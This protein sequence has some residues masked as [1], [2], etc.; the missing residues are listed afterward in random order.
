MSDADAVTAALAGLID[1]LRGLPQGADDAMRI[2]RITML[3]QL[4]A[5]AAAAQTVEAA[6]FA[7][8]QRA[9][10]RAVGVPAAQ[11][12]RGV[13]AQVGLAR[14]ISPHQA[15]RYLGW[16]TVL[17]TELP[18]TFTALAA[19]KVPERRAE[20]VARETIW[21]TRAHRLAVDAE[22]GPQL[23]TLGDRQV[24]AQARGIGYRLDP[25]GFV[26]R[27]AKAET[28]RR[29]WLRPA[30][31]AMVRLTALLPVAQGVACY[32]ALTRA[33]DTST[34]VGDERG[35]GQLMADTLV[36][37]VTGQTAA[38]DVP[39]SI[40]LTITD[41]ALLHNGTEPAIVDGYGPIPAEQARDLITKPG[42][43]TPMWI[44]RLYTNPESGQL[45]AMESKQRFFTAGQ[46][47]FIRIRDQYCR[48]PYCGAPIRHADH[49]RPA[50]DGGP[51]AIRN[52]QGNCEACNHAK[53]APGWTT[54]VI[55]NDDGVHEVETTTPTGHTYRSRAPDPPRRDVA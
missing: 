13:A 14:R 12:G 31:E 44:R 15:A 19:G 36:E 16:A 35:R 28:E 1:T 20:I 43:A 47:H 27:R 42:D 52:G 55:D 8:S 22:L 7:A 40:N 30:P 17:V 6:A 2:E 33:A 23:A 21:L 46:R 25:A 49:V 5:V 41:Q 11:V 53:Q 54:R 3:E 4:K 18:H 37:R 32:A 34:A 45:I 51:T 39:V 38:Q 29:V 9:A 48:T 26:E 50:I 10:Q 24:E